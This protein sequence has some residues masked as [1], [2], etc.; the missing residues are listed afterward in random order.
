MIQSCKFDKNKDFQEVV[1]GLALSIEM[2][3][4]SGVVK[5]T[6]DS[7]PYSK[8][9]NVEE[10]GHYLNDPIDIAMAADKLGQRMVVNTQTKTDNPE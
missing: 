9:E 10:V 7:T 6:V 4:V 2:A 5:D 1:P 8:I 3:L